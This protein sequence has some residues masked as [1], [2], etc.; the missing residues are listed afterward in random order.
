M[1]TVLNVSRCAR[2][3]PV[4]SSINM[5]FSLG[6]WLALPFAGHAAEVGR[7]AFELQVTDQYRWTG[8][9]V[10]IVAE[11]VSRARLLD[12]LRRK[13][14]IEVRLQDV[15]D[16]DISVRLIDVPLLDAV[17]ALVPAGS[18]YAIRFGE[19]ELEIPPPGVAQKKQGGPEVRG[20]DL[21]TKDRTRPL[22]EEMRTDIKVAAQDWRP[23]PPRE[24][25]DLKPMAER[26]TEVAPGKSPKRPLEMA[27][28]EVTPRLNFTIRAPNEIEL[29]DIALVP[30]GFTDNP[31]VTGP[32]LFVLR[33]PAG[34]FLYFGALPDP[35][36]MHSY[37]TDGTHSSER[38]EEGS[39]GIWLPSELA[40]PERLAS[41][42]LEFYD[43]R[44]VDL[45]AALDSRTIREL[46]DV[47]EPMGRVSGENLSQAMERSTQ[48]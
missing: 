45:P 46:V 17:A 19:R 16:E 25:K 28:A 36:E 33:G 35:L 32:F 8:M 40:S 21:P 44:R 13:H 38:A 5:V 30:G 23:P 12:E 27:A 1:A 42:S 6:I 7:P 9:Q 37:Q 34:E 41:L 48:Q 10:T 26:V 39:F 29:L 18:R 2:S 22:P 20:A 4:G 47:A 11:K 31:V 15:Q 24:G 3:S 43:A 14:Q